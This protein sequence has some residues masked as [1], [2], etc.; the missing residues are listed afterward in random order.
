M[1][2]G[3]AHPAGRSLRVAAVLAPDPGQP[4]QLRLTGP[5]GEVMALARLAKL[6]ADPPL[7][8]QPRRIHFPDGTLFETP[9]HA[10]VA[11]MFPSPA[12][13]LLHRMEAF[14]LQ[15]FAVV[16]L[17]VLSIWVLWRHGLDLLVAAAVA[18]TPA[19]LVTA[20]D[21]GALRTIDRLH[22]EPSGLS[23][24]EQ[25]RLRATLERLSAALD[26]EERPPRLDLAF[27]D[28]PGLGPNAMA[29]PGGTIV[30]TDELVTTF[31]QEDLLAGVIAHE[32]GNVAEQHGLR[33]VYRTISVALIFA[34]LAGDG[35]PIAEEV[36]VQG[37][38]FVALAYSRENERAA[39]R[40]AVGLTRRAGYDPAALATFFDR[41]E[42]DFGPEPPAWLS[43]H[44]GHS[45]RAAQIR[46]LA[47]SR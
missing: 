14:R 38:L 31:P 39:D 44:P 11:A 47:E 19:P 32:I 29:L 17:L 43:T 33:Q 41:L 34:L 3:H 28:M 12:A 16:A 6:R 35:T 4:G 27:R 18:M 2:H 24:A 46:A 40:F 8:R 7:G 26:P 13:A 22:A 42:A 9:D 23:P 10:G 1:L 30:L 15:L 37:G 25:A 21:T 20:M 5:E 36:A 45:D